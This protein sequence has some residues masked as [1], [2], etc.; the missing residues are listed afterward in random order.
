[1]LSIIIL[2]YKNPPLLRLCLKSVTASISRDFKYEIIA[3]D[4]A[5]E[6]ETRSVITEEFPSVKLIPLKENLG[7]TRANNIGLK[8]AIGDQLL[9]LNVDIAPLA[10]SIEK[11][12]HYM[13]NRPQIGMLGPELLNFDGTHQ[14]SC[15]RFYSPWTIIYRRLPF[16]LPFM[17]RELS[18][19]R[20]ADA[21]LKQTQPVDWLMGSAILIS[22]EA[23]EKVGPMDESFFHYFND[24]D[25]AQ[26]FWEN[27]FEVVYYPLVS[28]Y[29]YQKPG[30]RRFGLLGPI[31]NKQTRWHIRDGIKYFR[32]YSGTQVVF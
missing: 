4:N 27:G 14:D 7:Y 21:D 3:V 5:S 15:F 28:M 9:I 6:Y 26:M 13:N 32:K 18:R 31:F 17:K 25:W 12:S 24:V 1:M 2:N 8:E 20:Y 30:S 22:R 10:G 19:F 29:H 11:M 23:Y 16:K